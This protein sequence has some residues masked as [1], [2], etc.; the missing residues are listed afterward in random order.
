MQTNKKGSSRNEEIRRNMSIMREDLRGMKATNDELTDF[1]EDLEKTRDDRV[2]DI[3]RRVSRE[4]T[5]NTDEKRE[6]IGRRMRFYLVHQT[7]RY[8]LN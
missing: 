1:I 8:E 4:V 6:K 5:D 7:R 2:N 3:L